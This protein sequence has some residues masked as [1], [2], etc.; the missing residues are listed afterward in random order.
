MTENNE[1]KEFDIQ[2]MHTIARENSLKFLGQIDDP[3]DR[4][5]ND[6]VKLDRQ[7][8]K[9]QDFTGYPYIVL[10]EYTLNDTNNSVNGLNGTFD[11]DMEFHVFGTRDSESEIALHDRINDQITNLVKGR[12]SLRLGDEARLARLQFIRQNRMPGQD[13]ADQPV[14]VYEFEVRGKLHLN[15]DK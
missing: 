14:I 15:M 6:L 1:Y 2:K 7:R 3:A 11:F 10:E 9:A 8:P 13:E 4:A 12:H 5:H